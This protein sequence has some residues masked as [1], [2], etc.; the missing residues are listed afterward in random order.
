MLL[1]RETNK[2]FYAFFYFYA[3]ELRVSAQ[4]A[5]GGLSKT[6]KLAF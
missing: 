5:I 1:F 2:H 6:R 3:F 4:S